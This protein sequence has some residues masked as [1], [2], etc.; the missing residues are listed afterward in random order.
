[1]MTPDTIFLI[2]CSIA[3]AGWI[4]IIFLSP[5]WRGYDKFV[6]GIVIALLAIAYTWVNASNF[7]PGL[8][9]KFGSLDGIAQ[10]FSNRYL[11]TAAWIH[12]LAFDLIAAV[13]IKNNSVRHGINHLLVIP[14][15]VFSCLLGPF[16]YLIYLLTR[17]IK[18]RNYFVENF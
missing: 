15:L 7:D 14:A 8:I 12:F 11:L 17:F 9:K 16:G 6:T 4:I 1:M 3:A 2:T 13:W 18:T 5:F 10:I